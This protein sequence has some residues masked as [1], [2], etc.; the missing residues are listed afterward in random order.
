MV[1]NEARRRTIAARR[2]YVEPEE[3]DEAPRPFK[4]KYILFLA[5]LTGTA[6][7]PALLWVVDSAGSA[8]ALTAAAFFGKTPKARLVKFYRKHNPA[9]V[10]EV[11]KLINKYAGDYPKMI[12]VL[13]AKYGDYGFFLN[14]ENDADFSKF[15][16]KELRKY[17]KWCER[18]YKQYMPYRLRVAFFNMYT[19]IDNLVRP[20]VTLVRSII[21][22]SAPTR[23]SKRTPR[24]PRAAPRAA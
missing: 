20:I 2:A 19:I 3:E 22:P 24:R 17:Y 12:K 14:W 23:S 9:K 6:V 21:F 18:Y 13:E 1:K 8:F 4:W 16:Q 11:P 5:L 7:L 10:D 15:A